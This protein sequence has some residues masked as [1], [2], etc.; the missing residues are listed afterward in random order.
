M[1]KYLIAVFLL[2]FVLVGPVSAETVKSDDVKERLALAKDLHD[3]RHIRDAIHADIEG[4]AQ[5][6]PQGDR[7]DFMRY[8]ALKINFDKLE[9][10]SIAYTADIYT[11]PE[12]RA[13]IVYYGSPDGQ[14]AE[15][16]GAIY[17]PKIA[18]DV[19]KEI[20]AAVMSV[21]LGDDP[22]Q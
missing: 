13:M 15:A 12:M 22:T 19:Q 1:L 7:E 16:K 2:S 10:L 14:S 6:I 5:Q 21:K 9:Q 3:I 8:V 20:D 18:K 17:G 11:V 4:Y